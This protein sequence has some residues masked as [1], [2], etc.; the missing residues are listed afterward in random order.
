MTLVQEL[1]IDETFE[2][3][4]R[5]ESLVEMPNSP[6][7]PKHYLPHGVPN[8]GPILRVISANGQRSLVVIDGEA[9]GFKVVTW[10]NPD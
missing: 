3:T 7:I 2:R 5:L 9:Q 10:P 8:G 6:S 1:E 4:Y